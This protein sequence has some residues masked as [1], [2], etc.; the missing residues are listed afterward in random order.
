MMKKLL[1]IFTLFFSDTTYAVLPAEKKLAQL[2][3]QQTRIMEE[4]LSTLESNLLPPNK[5]SISLLLSTQ[6]LSNI[7]IESVTAT[8]NGKSFSHQYSKDEIHG[9]TQG[10]MHPLASHKLPSGEY[11]LSIAVFYRKKG[12]K[13]HQQ[14]LKTRVTKKQLHTLLNVKVYMKETHSPLSISLIKL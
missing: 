3:V 13:S 12:A 8:I 9:L 5:D 10:A 2:V 4:T 11:D 7:T 1:F 14:F 6:N